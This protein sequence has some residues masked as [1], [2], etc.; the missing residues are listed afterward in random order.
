VVRLTRFIDASFHPGDAAQVDAVFMLQNAADPDARSLPVFLNAD[1][2]SP[3]SRG[4]AIPEVL[5]M[6][7]Y[8]CRK[9]RDGKTGI[10]TNGNFPRVRM[11]E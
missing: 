1:A 2:L 10:A 7:M 3:K 4:A 9:R 8:P 6:K 5:L 11:I